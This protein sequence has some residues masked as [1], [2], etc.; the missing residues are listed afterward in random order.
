MELSIIYSWIETMVF[1]AQDSNKSCGIT[2]L[3]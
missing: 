3:C 2:T 1:Q